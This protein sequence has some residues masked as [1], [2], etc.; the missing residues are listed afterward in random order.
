LG[1]I[2]IL[3]INLFRIKITLFNIFY[4]FF[5][6]VLK[7]IIIKNYLIINFFIIKFI[8]KLCCLV[9]SKKVRYATLAFRDRGQAVKKITIT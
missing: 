3:V 4:K 5:I 1:L 6:E 9:N 2:S 8:L 7:I